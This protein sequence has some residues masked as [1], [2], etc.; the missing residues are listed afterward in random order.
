MRLLLTAFFLAISCI[1]VFGQETFPVNGVNSS[2]E[3]IYAFTNAHIVISPN[4]EIKNGSLLIQGDR[5]LAV[6]SNLT[7]PKGSIINDL[8]GDF[9]YPSFIDLYT[10]YGLPEIKERESY[11][12]RPQYKSKKKGAYHWNEAIHPEINASDKFINN[13]KSAKKYLTNGFG[14]VVTH[15]KDGIL[16]GTGALVLLSNRSNQENM[17]QKESATFYS[18]KKGRSKQKNP[19]SLMGSIALIRQ[20]LLDA[21]WYSL[22]SEQINLSY[23]SYNKTKDLPK[24]FSISNVLD[25]QRVFKIADEY[26]IDFIIKGNGKEYSRINEVI[27]CE[28]PV[29]I[30][31][32]FPNAY[33]VSNPETTEWIS[34]QKLKNWESCPY[35]PSILAKNKI[36]FCITSSDL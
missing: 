3:P 32:N 28:S 36:K 12:Y 16:R 31:L 6:D 1:W 30:P 9:I 2:F 22:Q 26:E 29:I 27:A 33:D 18:F 17:I 10:N 21:E 13:T 20:T 34:L 15:L 24:I 14:A 11:S 5:I 8:Q 4:S 23:L 35:N 19:T 25:Y 7:I